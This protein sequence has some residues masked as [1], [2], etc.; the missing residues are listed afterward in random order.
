MTTS[1]GRMKRHGRRAIFRFRRLRLRCTL[2]TVRRFPIAL[3][4]LCSGLFVAGFS[5]SGKLVADD[6]QKDIFP[7]VKKYC[8]ACHSGSTPAGGIPL[9]SYLTEASIKAHP[10]HWEKV[11]TN[12]ANKRMPPTGSPMPSQVQRDQVAAYIRSRLATAVPASRRV[13][14]RRLNRDEYN[15]TIRDLFG[16]DLRPADDFP[17]DDVGYGFDNIGDVLSIS[18]LHMEKYIK[19]AQQ[20][21]GVAIYTPGIR[22]YRVQAADIDAP[23]SNA[24]EEGGRL[25][26]SNSEIQ[27][28][29]ASP[30]EGDYKLTVA[31]YQTK[32]GPENA[33]MALRLNGKDLQVVDVSAGRGR[34][35]TFE[36]SFR[37][38]Y[39]QG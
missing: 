33:K 4:G 39:G 31:A 34:P 24:T 37:A 19:A 14:I 6:Y 32:A 13:T 29:V 2:M 3:L 25:M 38:K 27:M 8:A 18:P 21:A 22:K 1:S 23:A 36:V 7:V 30:I 35:Q 10:G 16:V 17:S 11:L 9:G 12:L 28:P 15:N 26:Y 20:V 5:A